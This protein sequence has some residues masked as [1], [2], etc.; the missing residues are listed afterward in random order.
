MTAVEFSEIIRN[1]AIVVGGG[2]GV[3]L[4]VWRVVVANRQSR[5][6]TLQA[7]IARRSHITEVF[8][9]A[10]ALLDDRKLEIRLGAI[11][12]LQQISRDFSQ[13]QPIVLDLL[14]AYV[15]E[16]TRDVEFDEPPLDIKEITEFLRAAYEVGEND[17]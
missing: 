6:T 17:G 7:D 13:F 2:V 8:T 16:R 3:A 14:S 12:S 10:V 4:A 9:S 5:A 15:R 11:Y 1:W